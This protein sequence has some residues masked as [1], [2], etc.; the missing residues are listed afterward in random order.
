MCVGVGAGLCALRVDLEPYSANIDAGMASARIGAWTIGASPGEMTWFFMDETL[1]TTYGSGT[2]ST[3]GPSA[4]VNMEVDVSVPTGTR[5]V[6]VHYSVGNPSPTANAGIDDTYLYLTATGPPAMPAGFFAQPVLPGA[7]PFA[8]TL[9]WSD[10][11]GNSEWFQVWVGQGTT[12]AYTKWTQD[13]NLQLP[14]L[15]GGDYDCYVRGF[16]TQHGYGPWADASFSIIHDLPMA[17]TPV[18]PSGVLNPLTGRSPTFSWT[19]NDYATY[20]QV[21]VVRDGRPFL[22]DW[23]SGF[24]N[25][26]F[27]NVVFPGGNY[28]W[29]VQGWN[30][31]GSTWSPG[32]Q[33]S[34][35]VTP[36]GQPVY[37]GL[38]VG[39]PTAR[40]VTYGWDEL[41]GAA[42]YQ[43]QIERDG[44]EFH[45]KWYS[46]S[47]VTSSGAVYI[48]VSG[49]H[50]G[51]HT[52]RVRAWNVD[53]LGP[54]MANEFDYGKPFSV[55]GSAAHLQWRVPPVDD[56]S[57]EW[58][59]IWIGVGATPVY[60]K[61]HSRSE[62]VYDPPTDFWTLTFVTPLSSGAYKAYVR[63]WNS[64]WGTSAWSDPSD[65]VVP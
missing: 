6:E 11:L 65:L 44:S 14:G 26:Y 18:A 21:F 40:S 9:S 49:H 36:P 56:P 46:A 41:D 10:P 4:Y 58:H 47:A 17:A 43:F 60:Q 61:W 5:M 31:N 42:W 28:Q 39:S 54:W 32:M 59:Q 8:R 13:V 33:F 23:L 29:W 55:G 27:P 63:A 37:R 64:G 57:I 51:R 12:T 7:N 38:G 20:S 34:I 53:G 52:W 1:S 3:Q 16:N 30:P 22:A 50:W 48:A 62:L 2:T 25:G 45:S 24:A 19:G 15:P 35:P